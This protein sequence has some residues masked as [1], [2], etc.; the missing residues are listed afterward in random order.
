[1][2]KSTKN[3]VFIE[4]AHSLAK[5]ST[6]SRRG[7]GCVLTNMHNHIIA[8]GYNGVGR[9]L[10]HC[11]EVPCNGATYTSGQGLA[12]CEAIHAEQNALMQCANVKDIYKA[13]ITCSPCMHC[14]KL[15]LNTGVK[16]II[17]SE[18]YDPEPLIMLNQNGILVTY[19]GTT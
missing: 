9:G 19:Y 3:D 4:I 18:I 15:F 14:A 2:H 10:V 1:M 12:K 13:Y 17:Y 16:E 6:C 7:V 11:T 5:L 8:T